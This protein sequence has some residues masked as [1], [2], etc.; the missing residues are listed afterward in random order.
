VIV[1]DASHDELGSS[2]ALSADAKTLVT[3]APHS[4]MNMGYVKVY[5]TD[6]DGWNPM[7]LGQTIYGEAVDDYFGDS[8]DIS[9][10]GRT[11][12]IG[13]PGVYELSD[14]SGYVRVYYLESDSLSSSWKQ[15]GQD[16]TGEAVSDSFGESILL[17]EDGIILAIGAWTNDGNG[18][19]S[20]HVRVY[21]LKDSGTSWEQ[22]GQDINGDASDDGS[23]HSVSL[24]AD[25]KTVAI[26]QLDNSENSDW[27]GHVR[28]Y[29]INSEG[30]SWEQLGQ[31]IAGVEPY[32][33]FGESVTLSPDGKVLAVGAPSLYIRYVRVYYL[34]TND[35][36]SSWKQIG[37]DIIGEEPDEGFGISV[38]MSEDGETLA[39]GAQSNNG[40]GANSGRVMV[41]Q[42]DDSST[43]WTQLGEDI[44]GDAAFDVLGWKV[45]LSADSRTLAIGSKYTDENGSDSGSVKVFSI[46]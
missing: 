11:I 13:A 29:Q 30:S 39:I 7:Q 42:W 32:D 36:G 44:H 35:I 26:G 9:R 23:G 19:D 5:R 43:S 8:V 12:A 10:D 25:G 40:N 22:L 6:D 2:L 17:S 41:Y 33:S 3:G 15:V 31:N 24:S 16:I 4:N 18:V 34:E 37:Q 38:S 20:G 1:G 28:V 21:Q 46:T 14:Q 27:L 45:S